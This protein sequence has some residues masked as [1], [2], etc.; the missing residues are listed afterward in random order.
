MEEEEGMGDKETEEQEE[1]VE[2]PDSLFL[3]K[4]L[5]TLSPVS[6]C[7]GLAFSNLTFAFYADHS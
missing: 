7:S 2:W 4:P 3:L 6:L 5:V 1:E